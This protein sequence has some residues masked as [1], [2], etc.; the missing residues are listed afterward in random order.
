MAGPWGSW[1]RC[2]VPI[3]DTVGAGHV[4]ALSCGGGTT[5]HRSQRDF[6]SRLS[7]HTSKHMCVRIQGRGWN[8]W[9]RTAGGLQGP[10]CGPAGS[11]QAPGGAP[12]AASD[13]SAAAQAAGPSEA[14][15]SRC[16]R[17]TALT[18]TPCVTT[19]L[20]ILLSSASGTPRR[21]AGH[22]WGC[23]QYSASLQG[24]VLDFNNC[25][26]KAN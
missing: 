17:T 12:T 8:P 19:V 10:H 13:V 7:T 21:W 5:G 20:P 15:S 9:A 23:A 16:T 24:L 22:F 26:H 6:K 2:V 1:V 18:A 25:D 3:S 14:T 4:M 11:P